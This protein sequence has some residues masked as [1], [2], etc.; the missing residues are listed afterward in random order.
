MKGFQA[1]P[2]LVGLSLCSASAAILYVWFKTRNLEKDEVDSVAPVKKSKSIPKL[3]GHSGRA[4]TKIQSEIAN[5]VVPLVLGRNGTNVRSIENQTQTKISFRRKNDTHQ[6]CEISGQYENVMKAADL[7]KVEAS[8]S[9]HV[10]EELNVPQSAYC[11]IIGR[12]GKTLQDICRRSQ[13]QVHINAAP[14]GDKNVRRIMVTG[15][16]SQVNMAIRLIDEKVREDANERD[17]ELKREPRGTTRSPSNSES[18]GSIYTS[19]ERLNVASSSNVNSDSQL[20]VYVSAIASPDRFWVQMVG[21]HTAKLDSLV[22]EMTEYYSQLENQRLHKVEDPCLGQ[23]VTAMFKYDS[24]WYRARIVG[25]LPNDYDP[26]NVVLDLFFLDYG[27]SEYVQPDEV[28]EIRTDFLTLRFQAIECFL[29]HCQPMYP[30]KDN[31]WS[32]EATARFEE[33]THGEFRLNYFRPRIR[34]NCFFFCWVSVA[35]WKQLNAKIVT[36]KERFRGADLAQREGSPVP[37]IEL[38]DTVEGKLSTF[39]C[40]FLSRLH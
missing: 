25:I 12:C 29:A 10:T 17:A 2:V 4:I 9:L 24:K 36:T 18:I 34:N 23:I 32:R 11:K 35:K 16:R 31:Q 21:P 14:T 37:G 5:D 6:V 20:K 1:L 39:F 15:S 8:R 7:V 33:L 19:N 40:V 30:E 22:D 3:S 13:A 28:F 27:D 38:Y 26:R